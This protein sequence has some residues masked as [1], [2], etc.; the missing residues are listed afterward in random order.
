MENWISSLISKSKPTLHA[1]F[2]KSTVTPYDPFSAGQVG[3]T[4]SFL[5]DPSSP[6]RLNGETLGTALFN[7]ESFE[8]RVLWHQVKCSLIG[9]RVPV[10]E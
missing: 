1:S 9:F 3:P 5:G 6:H 4:A 8:V 10:Y 2:L 7:N